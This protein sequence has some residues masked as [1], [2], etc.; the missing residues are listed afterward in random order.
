MRFFYFVIFLFIFGLAED[1]KIQE[2]D[3]DQK[4]LNFTPSLIQDS[5][6]A[7]FGFNLTYAHFYHRRYFDTISFNSL[8]VAF[9]MGKLFQKDQVFV[10]FYLDGAAGR[11]KSDALYA[12]FSGLKVGGKLLDGK[13]TPYFKVGLNLMHFPFEYKEQQFNAYGLDSEVGVFFDIK[14]GYGIGL[15]YRHTFDRAY[16]LRLNDIHTSIVMLGFAYYDF[17]LEW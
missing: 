3:Q 13:I 12:L 6:Y 15:S 1:L 5:Y 7:S 16:K 10:A 4:A 11:G 14:N 17:D 8:S 2:N 9:D